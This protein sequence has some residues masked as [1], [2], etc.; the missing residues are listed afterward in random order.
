MKIKSKTEVVQLCPTLHDPMDC[1]LPGS[2]IHGIFPS[3]STGVECYC[4]L[5]FSCLACTK[6]TIYYVALTSKKADAQ[7]MTRI[8]SELWHNGRVISCASAFLDVRASFILITSLKYLAHS[9]C[10]MLVCLVS[11]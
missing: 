9:G 5:H 1:S 4:F 2:S 10:P 8:H 11:E 7:E 3:K 6:V